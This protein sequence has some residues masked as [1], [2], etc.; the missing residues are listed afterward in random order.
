MDI[1]RLKIFVAVVDEGGFS[2]AARKLYM[3]QP[4]VSIAI[5]KLEEEL[6]V[7][8]FDA[9]ARRKQLTH[10][11][12]RLLHHARELLR[13]VSRLESEIHGLSGT[14]T[15][16]LTVVCPSML[17]TYFLPDLLGQFMTQHPQ[18]TASI[19]QQGTQDIEKK[20]RQ[21]DIELGVIVGELTESDPELEV[22]PLVHERL[23]LAVSEDHDFAKRHFVRYE[24]LHE[25]PMFIYESGYFIRKAFMRECARAGVQPDL[26]LQANFLPLLVRMAR[27]GAGVTL[28]LQLMKDQEKGLCLVPLVPASTLTLLLAKPRDKSISIV[29][30]AFFD[31]LVEE[32]RS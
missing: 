12:E 1:K 26:R 6:K 2:A 8:L 3:A 18:L 23:C 19:S 31:W 17:A 25:V 4:A 7:E 13:Q 27:N 9:S 14:L 16:Q 32:F 28:G 21:R 29:N 10:E 30:Q 22:I 20:L 15:G 5:R 11:G 24:Q